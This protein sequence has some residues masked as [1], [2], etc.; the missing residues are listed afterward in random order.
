MPASSLDLWPEI[1]TEKLRTPVSILREQAALLGQKTQNLLEAGVST[2]TFEGS[3][4]H[5][6]FILAPSL[7]YSTELFTVEHRIELYPV[8]G[9]AN[10]IR[11]RMDTEDQFIGW[12]RIQLSSDATQRLVQALLAQINS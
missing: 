7:D 8:F 2:T 9:I 12:I 5:S 6:F 4:R 3:F 11:V 1:P 10:G